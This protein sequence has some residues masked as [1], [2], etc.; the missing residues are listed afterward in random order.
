[1][2]ERTTFPTGYAGC[3]ITVVTERLGEEAWAAVSTIRHSRDGVIRTIDLPVSDR[4]F[5]TAADAQDFALRQA[6]RWL[7]HNMPVDEKKTA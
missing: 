1:M 7:E 5:D 2:V 4:R 6:T 3:E